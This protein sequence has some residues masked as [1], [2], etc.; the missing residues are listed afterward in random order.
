MVDYNKNN[1][2][3]FKKEMYGLQLF[4]QYAMLGVENKNGMWYKIN[5]RVLYAGTNG[6]FE[7]FTKLLSSDFSIR[8][9]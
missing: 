1:A 8:K 6:H 7:E 4:G 5:P 9:K 3:K 2:N